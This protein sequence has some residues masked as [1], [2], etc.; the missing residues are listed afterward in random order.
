MPDD[1]P[2]PD[3]PQESVG[4]PAA[5]PA[6]PASAPD[7]GDSLAQMNQ[8]LESLSQRL[9]EPAEQ[10]TPD[11]WEVLNQPPD[12]FED[13]APQPQQTGQPS[14][15]EELESALRELV[16]EEAQS[17]VQPYFQR[18]ETQRRAEAIRS[19]ASEFQDFAEPEVLG[20]ITQ[21]LD[22]LAEAYGNPMLRT[23]P[24]LAR[25]LYFAQ[26]GQAAALAETPA[27]AVSPSASLETAAGPGNQGEDA[28]EQDRYVG[29]LMATIPQGRDAF[30]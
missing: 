10:E 5:Q 1:A 12:D 28:S 26:K 4:Q 7:I 20:P 13:D 3:A 19:L 8:A 23:D 17:L 2:T 22:Q 9:P 18:Q 6:E 11:P 29:A 25:A 24:V 27:E 21:Q 30:T 14:D 16:R 15:D